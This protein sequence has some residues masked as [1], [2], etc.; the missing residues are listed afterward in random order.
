MS[1]AKHRSAR[2]AAR[3][4]LAMAIAAP[5]VLVAGVGV[6]A[7]D[8]PETIDDLPSLTDNEVDQFRE[9][10]EVPDIEAITVPDIEPFEPDVSSSGGDT[11]VSLD[12]D[13]LFAFGTS[14][15][16]SAAEDAVVEAA[17]DIPDGAEVD[18]VGHSDSVGAPARNRTLS[19]QRAQAVADVVEEE[20][21]DLDLTVTGKGESD[22]VEP[23]TQGGE[24]NPEG[25]E[26]NRRVEIRYGG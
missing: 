26:K 6:A 21:D 14:E 19:K 2:T 1:T 22:P 16:S 3:S 23:N 8:E 12:T 11:V 9:K 25:R 10:I 13:V 7:A 15:L 18:V 17:Q 24:D 5:M 4:R 20:R